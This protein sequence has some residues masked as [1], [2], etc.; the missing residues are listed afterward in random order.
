[1]AAEFAAKVAARAA[2]RH[3]PGDS[4]RSVGLG[5]GSDGDVE[6]KEQK[7]PQQPPAGEMDVAGQNVPQ[8]PPGAPQH[9]S[10]DESVKH[11]PPSSV[12]VIQ[13]PSPQPT[14]SP[15]VSVEQQ[16]AASDASDTADVSVTC[17]VQQ[18]LVSLTPLSAASVT[19][20]SVPASSP[21]FSSPAAPMPLSSV[22]ADISVPV[23][24][25]TTVVEDIG[26]EADEC[27]TGEPSAAAEPHSMSVASA[28]SSS[29][30][31]GG[32]SVSVNDAAN[33]VDSETSSSSG[34][35]LMCLSP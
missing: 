30:S 6:I 14:S 29:T 25:S 9:L 5:G 4:S 19:S 22:P 18:S 7:Q 1:V 2:E 20:A 12:V 15:A 31:A 3:L 17:D 23:T 13:P 28:V 16:A 8:H 27:D 11:P 35:L 24:S 33:R 32:V 21:A 26:V 34:R 10:T